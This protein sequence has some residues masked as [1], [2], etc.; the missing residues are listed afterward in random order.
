M[1][2]DLSKILIELETARSFIDRAEHSIRL[3]FANNL[4]EP[5]QTV[6]ESDQTNGVAEDERQGTLFDMTPYVD[7][8]DATRAAGTV[9]EAT[10]PVPKRGLPRVS[11]EMAAERLNRF[12]AGNQAALLDRAHVNEIFGY[13]R[14][15]GSQFIDHAVKR[16]ALGYVPFGKQMKFLSVDVRNFIDSYFSS[17]E[18][19]AQ[20]RLLFPRKHRKDK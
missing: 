12:C 5:G 10:R 9:T 6:Q 8:S 16:G 3:L 1:K 18:G 11:R 4:E 14:T 19:K 7:R 13:S 20:S 17:P 15:S 2:N